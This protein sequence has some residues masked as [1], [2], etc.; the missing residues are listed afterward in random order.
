MQ[1]T[2]GKDVSNP[3]RV[4]AGKITTWGK[5]KPILTIMAVVIVIA[6]LVEVIG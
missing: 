5:K 2:E 4:V 3:I 6:I 1:D